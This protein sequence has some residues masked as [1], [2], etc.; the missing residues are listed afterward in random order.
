MTTTGG[1]TTTTTSGGDAFADFLLGYPSAVQRAYPA[2]NFGGEGWY[3]QFFVQDDF[4]VNEHLTINMGLRYEYSPWLT[5]YK[6]QVGTF[7]PTQ[8]QPVIVGG[9]G[10]VPD[11]SGQ[12]A[13]AQAYA[14]FGKYIQTSS[15]AGLPYN[16]TYP[17][18]TQFAPRVGVAV[19]LTPKTVIRSGFGIFYE[20]EGTS[21]RVNLNMLP[22]R[23]N[24]TQNQT[25]NVAPT[26]TLANYFLGA[27]LGSALAN[28]SLVPTRVH[29]AVGQNIHYSLDV[30]HQ[31]STHDVFDVAFVGNRGVHLN[32]AADDNDPAPG[33]GTIQTRRPYQPWGTISFNTQDLSHN[34]SSLQTKFDHRFSHG[35]S[36]LTSYTFSK[37]LAYGPTPAVGGNNGFEYALSA[38]D[39]P[40]NLAI[41]ATYALPVGRGRMFL[42]KSNRLVDAFIGGWQLQ[43]IIDLRSGTPYTPSIN[44]DR[45]NTGVGGQR[46]NYYPAG[47]TPNFRRSLATW[48]DRGCYADADVYKYGTL[49]ANTLRSDVGRQYDGSLFKNFALPG[50]S[51]L[52]FRLE[53]FNISNSATFSAPSTNID[54][55]TGGQITGSSSPRNLQL[56]L[57][58]N[59]LIFPRSGRHEIR[60]S[61][62]VDFCSGGCLDGDVCH[63]TGDYP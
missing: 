57:K 63:R 39:V 55:S 9:Y 53:V 8:A 31:F 28:P 58:Y 5:G 1:T 45:A 27:P 21:G 10:A 49:R 7:D 26:R 16:M 15:T 38:F 47:C 24:E 29:L 11:L 37:W 60:N 30:Q 50:E 35:F 43:T 56:A 62:K 54:S 23:L 13:A 51:T 19:S 4:R 61:P 6:G 48:F 34:Y 52:S 59:F 2:T 33:P 12:P 32:T 14:T 36:I 46:P 41:S 20:P 25:Q 22:F 42:G 40:H 3:R 17:D 18:K 44:G